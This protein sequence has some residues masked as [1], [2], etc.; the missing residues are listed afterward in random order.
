MRA[1]MQQNS[2][3]LPLPHHKLAK[4]RERARLK[5][6]LFDNYSNPN[7][8]SD[9]DLYLGIKSVYKVLWLYISFQENI[10]NN[11]EV[12]YAQIAAIFGY[13]PRKPQLLAQKLPLPCTNPVIKTSKYVWKWHDIKQI[14][15]R[16]VD[17][18][19]IKELAT[20]L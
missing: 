10:K 7:I 11:S 19:V 3:E 2:E 5:K 8:L 13:D 6:P 20:R 9:H 16:L 18:H 12:T 1:V 17:S 4:L 14:V 15:R